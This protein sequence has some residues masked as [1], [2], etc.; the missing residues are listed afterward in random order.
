VVLGA[1]LGAG[2]AASALSS[3]QSADH[4]PSAA[5][6]L[7]RD[8]GARVNGDT[9][10]VTG[11]GGH[12][13]GV[14][15]RPNFIVSLGSDEQIVGGGK[16][17]ELG[18][19]GQGDTIVAGSG[20][21]ELIHGDQNGTVV[22]GGA[23]H[24]LVI[25][26][27]PDTTIDVKSPT[28]EVILTGHDD[29]VVCSGDSFHDQIYVNRSDAVNKTCHKDHDPVRPDTQAVATVANAAS[30]N[31]ARGAGGPVAHAASVIGSG[32]DYDPYTAPCTP[33]EL[34]VCAVRFPPRWL[35]GF[36]ANEYVPAYSC[37]T[38]SHGGSEAPWLQNRSFAPF[39]TNLPNGVQVEETDPWPIG[40]SISHVS[41]TGSPGST[42]NRIATGTLTEGSSATNWTFGTASYTVVLYCTAIE[43]EAYSF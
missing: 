12:A 24:D 32:T 2:L 16:N 36:W 13:L 33:V 37:P 42:T 1:V 43:G 40:V 29:H 27:K 30:A 26:N 18:A 3:A 9:I 14:H 28:D 10:V 5:V 22:V 35:T 41:A 38:R 34:R 25:A 21:H 31:P 39:G 19:L 4:K 17:D 20:G 8:P 15:D 7:D 11:A 23:G 6:L